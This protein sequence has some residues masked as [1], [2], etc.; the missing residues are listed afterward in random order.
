MIKIGFIILLYIC[1]ADVPDEV[2]RLA[3]MA[4]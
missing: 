2:F 1:F 4:R 3:N